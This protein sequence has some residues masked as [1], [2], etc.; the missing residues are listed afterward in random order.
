MGI[1][2][3]G[4]LCRQFAPILALCLAISCSPTVHPGIYLGI[5]SFERLD[6]VL[7]SCAFTNSPGA[8]PN[9]QPSRTMSMTTM[10]IITTSSDMASLF[11]MLHTPCVELNADLYPTTELQFV[12][13]S[14]SISWINGNTHRGSDIEHQCIK[15]G[16]KFWR[17]GRI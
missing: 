16:L 4:G 15:P 5:C 2:G 3:F 6:Y 13:Y 14:I 12:L 17:Q 10:T 11:F 9:P 1:G 8:S 7:L